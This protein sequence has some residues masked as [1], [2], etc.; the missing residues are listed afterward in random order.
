MHNRSWTGDAGT[1]EI[2]ILGETD[3][4]KEY[5]S[6]SRDHHFY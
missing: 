2:Q 5:A 3:V 1:T 6:E 4:T